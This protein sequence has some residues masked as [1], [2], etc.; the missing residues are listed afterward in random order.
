MAAFLHAT[1]DT[2]RD[3]RR[4]APFDAMEPGHLRFLAENL[5][6]E[7]FAAGAEVLVPG[8]GEPRY[9]YIVRSGSVLS[10]QAVARTEEDESGWQLAAGDCFPLGAL[11]AKRPVASLYRATEDTTCFLLPA[12]RFQ[13]LLALSQ[14]MQAYCTRRLAVLLERSKKIIQSQY[15][16]AGAEQQSLT[17]P[18]SSVVRRTPV[19]CGPETPIQSVLETMHRLGIGS[20]IVTDGENR[21]IGIFTERDVLDRVALVRADL[22]APVSSVMTS[23]RLTALPPTAT[24]YDAALEMARHGFR[25]VLVTEQGR[26]AGIVSERDLF[27][28]QRVSLRQLSSGIR[29]AEDL[30]SLRQYARDIQQLAQNMLV[31]GVAAEQLTQLIA[32]LNDNLTQRLIELEAGREELRGVRFCWLA[33]G[34]EGRIEQTFSTDQDNGIIFAVPPGMDTEAARQAL[35]PMAERINRALDACGFTLC[36]GKIMAGNPTWCL[37]LEEWQQKFAGW[38]DAGAPEALLNASIFFDFRPLWGQETL[39]LQLRQ[40]LIGH[41][42]A[43]PRFLHQMA[44]NALRN[45]PPLGMWRDFV[46]EKKG[47]RPDTLDLK[48][49]GTTLFVDA[50]RIFSLATG[51]EHTQTAQRLR[52]SAPQLNVP[53]EEVEAWVEA[54]FLIQ[55]IRLKNQ[56]AQSGRGES[57]D[58]RLNPGAL[59]ELDQ[60][61]LKEAFRQAKK[62]QA[63]LGMD[64]QV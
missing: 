8:R 53:P 61:I 23:G 5:T 24:A 13:E 34:S 31:Q 43:N 26:L 41:A 38:I 25:H 36:K 33:L 57:M 15:S 21:P 44:A 11:V 39:A 62:L 1:E 48:M 17:S 28:I 45:R 18:L 54:F 55:T 56:Y 42:M 6:V 59:H 19:S 30:D 60:H 27:S 40:W 51:V 14:V 29:R 4:Y 32:T 7:K 47:E 58:N 2:I 37:A 46:V 64:Y 22:A 63:R 3:L 35:L 9:L 10:E 52:L 12:V 16:E 49:N 20:M 50:A